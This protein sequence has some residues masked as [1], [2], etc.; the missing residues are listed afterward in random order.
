MARV[1]WEVQESRRGWLV[2][3]QARAGDAAGW[4]ALV[5]R[6]RRVLVTSGCLEEVLDHAT[7]WPTRLHALAAVQRAGVEGEVSPWR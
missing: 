5:A 4:E 7:G 2:V 1:S 6:G 3:R